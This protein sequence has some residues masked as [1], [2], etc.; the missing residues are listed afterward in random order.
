MKLIHTVKLTLNN[1][2]V[3]KIQFHKE[4]R[5]LLALA[6]FRVKKYTD[7]SAWTHSNTAYINPGTDATQNPRD[8]EWRQKTWQS[9]FM[10]ILKFV[11][12][13]FTKTQITAL[14][15]LDVKI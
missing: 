15:V 7:L 1:L 11:P 9:G 3:N 6:E 13:G 4:Q 10:A 14:R 5:N 8:L 2:Q 12:S